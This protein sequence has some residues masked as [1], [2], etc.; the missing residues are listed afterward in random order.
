MPN[1]LRWFNRVKCV[2]NLF[3]S[4][5]QT[6]QANPNALTAQIVEEADRNKLPDLY[7]LSQLV[8]VVQRAILASII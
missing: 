7:N 6:L 8:K 5:A 3:T 2:H 1:L 4:I